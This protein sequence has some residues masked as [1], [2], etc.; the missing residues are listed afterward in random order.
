MIWLIRQFLYLRKAI[1]AVDSPRQ[2]ALGFA[3]G[4]L[5]GLM[6]KGNLLVV[7]LSMVILSCRM[8][9]A[10]AMLSTLT[11]SGVG[12]LADPLTHRLGLALLEW[13]LLRPLWTRLYSLPLVPWTDFN[14]TVVLGSFVLGLALLY[15]AYHLAWT[16]CERRRIKRAEKAGSGGQEPVAQPENSTPEPSPAT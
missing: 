13:P 2:V 15:P 14:N 4:M 8:N 16:V 9:L 12:M 10:V 6:P 3:L 5:L 11:F 7:L 1:T